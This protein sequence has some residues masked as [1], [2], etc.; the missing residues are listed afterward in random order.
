MRVVGERL[1]AVQHVPQVDAEVVEAAERAR[2]ASSS[3]PNRNVGGT[4]RSR[5]PAA[6]RRVDVGVDRVGLADRLREEAQPAALDVD[7]RTAARSVP[8][9]ALVDGHA[10]PTFS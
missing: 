9:H 6:A 10:Q 1:L 2:G 8:M 7:A 3:M 4:G 5:W